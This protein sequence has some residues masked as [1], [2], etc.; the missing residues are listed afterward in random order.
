MQSGG[1]FVSTRRPRAPGTQLTPIPRA[2]EIDDEVEIIE[3]RARLSTS[4]SRF[5][6][7]AAAGRCSPIR[8][9]T[10]SFVYYFSPSGCSSHGSGIQLGEVNS[11][12]EV[13]PICP[14][15]PSSKCTVQ[16]L[17]LFDQPRRKYTR[18]IP[19]SQVT[20]NI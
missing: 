5:I 1:C 15:T 11:K 6:T 12:P 2:D 13:A 20:G 8:R 3:A 14:F 9:A 16:S 17:I 10:G 4:P 7:L 19:A 18:P